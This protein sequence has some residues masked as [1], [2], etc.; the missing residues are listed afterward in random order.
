M[1]QNENPLL[2]LFKK[3]NRYMDTLSSPYNTLFEM[4][5]NYQQALK[6]LS[7]TQTG[8]LIE[9]IEIIRPMYEHKVV[10]TT[11]D[12]LEKIQEL[13]KTNE[14]QFQILD[15]VEQSSVQCTHKCT[16]F[17][18]NL[19]N[20]DSKVSNFKS[21]LNKMELNLQHLN[22]L[23]TENE[24]LKRDI[25]LLRQERNMYSTK[26]TSLEEQLAT[27]TAELQQ[28]KQ[29]ELQYR[30]EYAKLEKKYTLVKQNSADGFKNL[31]NTM[32]ILKKTIDDYKIGFSKINVALQRVR[33]QVPGEIS[34]NEDNTIDVVLSTIDHISQQ[35]HNISTHNSTHSSSHA[36]HTMELM[37]LQSK[38]TKLRYHAQH[39][40]QFSRQL[41]TS[42]HLKPSHVSTLQRKLQDFEKESKFI[43][44]SFGSN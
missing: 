35:L 42:L 40:M 9:N 15:K 6:E 25:I 38:Y 16:D 33:T 19:K 39:V 22:Q 11:D 32:D 44:S 2:P 12:Y 31:L 28:S 41:V 43:D 29:S 24:S 23:S 7:G 8:Q 36:S 17:E 20:Y 13:K 18:S 37:E 21:S 34:F 26:I 4:A 27:I 14:K 10:Q 5:F 1:L 3:C 30:S